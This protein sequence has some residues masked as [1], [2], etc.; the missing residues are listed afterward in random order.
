M[1]KTLAERGR[2]YVEMANDNIRV[3][4]D[5]LYW[6][7]QKENLTYDFYPTFH[8]SLHLPSSLL[9]E[10]RKETARKRSDFFRGL[11]STGTTKRK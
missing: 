10:E 6:F 5:I 4:N 8:K 9:S 11:I 7:G 3:C 1:R 2:P